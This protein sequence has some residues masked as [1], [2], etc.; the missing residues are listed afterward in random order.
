MT[1]YLSTVMPVSAFSIE[2]LPL[3]LQLQI[4]SYAA[5]PPPGTDAAREIF[6]FRQPGR[7][8]PSDIVCYNHHN[9]RRPA[10]L[11]RWFFEQCCRSQGFAGRV[12]LMRTCRLA[13]QVALEAWKRDLKKI[14]KN[15][16]WRDEWCEILVDMMKQLI[17]GLKEG[18]AVSYQ[19]GHQYLFRNI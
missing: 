4:W 7:L 8:W 5:I 10:D 14:N 18:K 9:V 2:R 19:L 1:S 6:T 11:P 13:R 3:E 17:K 16:G 12:A 15:R